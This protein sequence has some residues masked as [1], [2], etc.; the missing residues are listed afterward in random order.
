MVVQS[1]AARRSEFAE[2][3]GLGR[4]AAAEQPRRGAARRTANQGLGRMNA[5]AACLITVVQYTGDKTIITTLCPGGKERVRRL[6]SMIETGS[7]RPRR[8]GH[9]PVQAGQHR[10]GL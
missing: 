7:G 5:P 8:D 2:Q 4:K 1:Y 6:M 9:A 3:I 10:G